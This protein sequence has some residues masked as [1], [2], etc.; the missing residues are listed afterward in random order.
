VLIPDDL[1]VDGFWYLASPYSKYRRNGVH[2][3]ERNLK[4]NLHLSHAWEDVMSI[5]SRLIEAHGLKVYSPIGTGHPVSVD[6]GIDPYSHDFWL[7]LDKNFVEQA[8]GLIVAGMLGWRDSFGIGQEIK[9]FGEAQKPRY[10]LDL[11]SWA[12]QPLP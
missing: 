5:H 12:V 6:A 10:F 4:D 9:W 3:S 8:F 1:R 7:K 2:Y 11:I